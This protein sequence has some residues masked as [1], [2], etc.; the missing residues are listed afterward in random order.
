[1]EKIIKFLKLYQK[2]NPRT[3]ATTTTIMRKVVVAKAA[4]ND[5]SIA[6]LTKRGKGKLSII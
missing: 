4:K 6:S 3:A 1:V 2:I 5:R